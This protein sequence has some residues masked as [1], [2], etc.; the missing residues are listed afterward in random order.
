MYQRLKNMLSIVT[1]LFILIFGA[2]FVQQNQ[3]DMFNGYDQLVYVQKATVTFKEQLQQL[4]TTH[5][6]VLAKRIVDVADNESGR[7]LNTYVPIGSDTL[8][9]TF[10]IQTDATRIA[11]SSD[12][13][14][15]VI[16][17]GDMTAD[18][19]ATALLKDY[20]VATVHNV[21]Y[22]IV[23]LRLLF[24][25]PQSLMIVFV[26]LIAY[27]S[28][29]LAEYISNMKTVGIRRLAGES[30][31]KIAIGGIY[32]D[33]LLMLVVAGVGL[34]GVS[35]W[36]AVNKLLSVPALLM[37][38]TPTVLWCG[39]LIIM[40]IVLS[41]VFY[42]LLQRQPIILSVKGK[43]P[44]RAIFTVVF[45]TQLLT[46]F[47]VMYSVYGVTQMG[48]DVHQLQL[49]KQEWEKF[50]EYYQ[51]TSLEHGG[52]ITDTQREDFYQ[53]LNQTVDVMYRSE[54][55]DNMHWS[56][57]QEKHSDYPTAEMV[58][59]VMHVNVSLLNKLDVRLS[60]EVK[61]AVSNMKQ[62]DKIVLIPRSKERAF[63]ALKKSWLT[64]LVRGLAPEDVVITDPHPDAK[65]EAYMYDD[66]EQVFTFPMFGTT[67][68]MV[69]NRAY[70]TDPIIIVHV[71]YMWGL[72]EMLVNNP[73][74]VE[75]LIKKH[76]MTAGFG[77]LTNGV[78]AITNRLYSV[79]AQRDMLVVATLIG[80]VSSIL[81]LVLLNM[82]Y[83]Y[84]G[85]KQYTIK[86]LAGYTQLAIHKKYVSVVV[87]GHLVL[88]GGAIWF[89][90]HP[91][92]TATPV[93]YM[94][95]VLGIFAWQLTQEKKANVQYLKG[96]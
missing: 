74:Q 96:E 53:E 32:K 61:Q 38:I 65:K 70:L 89:G 52:T 18:E 17:S 29:I 43:A 69:S 2:V 80:V 1:T 84:N 37:M 59:N 78:Q 83:F 25:M 7:L 21:P 27:A 23:L 36:L 42:Y 85:R 73:S 35:G 68:R 45:I 39:V 10:V 15:Y 66:G 3:S 14:M 6:L 40:N 24:Y 82:M 16:V 60:D 93:V 28:L 87:I 8:P 58:S 11:N 4:V 64:F 33:I 57:S 94:A 75:Y 91:V 9:D 88:M 46:V 44:M 56:D 90:L 79:K 48:Y 30:K 62:H 86:R 31:H 47:S 92:V 5:H 71:D 81:L 41:N 20:N 72:S 13:T 77:A 55:L 49:G 19:L 12:A 95:L 76:N 34:I 51:I 26:L 54:F 67:G 22:P 63:D 50:P